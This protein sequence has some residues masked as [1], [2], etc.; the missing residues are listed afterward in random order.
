MR[1]SEEDRTSEEDTASQIGARAA[2]CGRRGGAGRTRWV[3]RVGETAIGEGDANGR[4]EWN[5][6][7]GAPLSCRQHSLGCCI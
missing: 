3:A 2:N 1:I 6:S 5:L 4:V 7:D